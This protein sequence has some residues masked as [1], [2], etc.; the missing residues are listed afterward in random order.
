M[1]FYDFG[2]LEQ[3]VLGGAQVSVDMFVQ[4][5]LMYSTGRTIPVDR[6]AAHKWFNIAGAKGNRDA[7]E[8]RRGLASEMNEV[9]IAE[10]QRAARLFIATH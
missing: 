10:A 6:V 3:A 5:G 7:I 1:A 4:L 8:L 2:S 9:E